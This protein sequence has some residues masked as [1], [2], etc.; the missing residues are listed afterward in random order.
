[1]SS[2]SFT[3]LL[4]VWRDIASQ[5]LER[6]IGKCSKNA[7]THKRQ[8]SCCCLSGGVTLSVWFTTN[9]MC[10]KNNNIYM[11]REHAIIEWLRRVNSIVACCYSAKLC[12]H[13]AR[14][15]RSQPSE[16]GRAG[17]L[18]GHGVPSVARSNSHEKVQLNKSDFFDLFSK[19]DTG[20]RYWK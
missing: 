16:P 15:F 9:G 12:A 14:A 13:A 11:W 5:C 1:M 7:A 6:S 18:I 2:L 4:S 20:L 10:A 8:Q 3:F 17:N 19:I